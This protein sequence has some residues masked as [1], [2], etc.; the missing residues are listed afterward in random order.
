MD[1]FSSRAQL[2]LERQD[3][4]GGSDPHDA[5]IGIGR[6]LASAWYGLEDTSTMSAVRPKA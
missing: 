2:N 3:G 4:S 5:R 1:E 6:V